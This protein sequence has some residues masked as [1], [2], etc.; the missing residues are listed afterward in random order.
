MFIWSMKMKKQ[1]MLILLIVLLLAVAV[2]L[3]FVMGKPKASGS[4]TKFSGTTDLVT[5]IESFGWQVE[6][7]P[8]EEVEVTVPKEF[9][10]VYLNY[11]EIQKRQ[12]FDLTKYQG[13]RVRRTTFVLLNYPGYPDNMRADVL[14][15]GDRIVGADVCS[16]EIRGFMH[17]LDEL[18]EDAENAP[19]PLKEAKQTLK[20]IEEE[21]PETSAQET[22]E[23]VE[24]TADTEQKDETQETKE[25]QETESSQT[26]EDE[27]A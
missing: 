8:C 9:D 14:T 23:P 10:D 5:Y 4:E 11:N 20:Q 15:C 2:V 24:G 19:V 22:M 27:A 17:G 7:L 13:K 12:G 3:Y 16:L 21:K 18:K 26:A 6:P 1:R 25:T